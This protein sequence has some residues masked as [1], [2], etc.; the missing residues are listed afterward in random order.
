MKR[1]WNLV[2]A[3]VLA[4][5]MLLTSSAALAA[6]GADAAIVVCI[7]SQP[8]TI[9]PQMNSA[10]DGS[11][12]IKHLFEGLLKYDW[13]GKGIVLGMAESYETSEDGLTW[14]FKIR[15]DAKWSD[16]KDL[17]AEDFVYTWRRLVD[18]DNAAP[19]AGDM[20]QFLLNGMAI[21]NGEKAPEE[22]GV[23]AIDAKTLEVKLENPCAF[24][25][26]IMAFPAY[27]P[28][29]QDIVEANGTGW[30]N[31]P[32]TLI[33][34][35]AYKLE[36]WTMDE[37]IVLVPNPEYYDVDKVVAKRLVFKLLSDPIAKLAAVRNGE[38]HWTDD[39]PT[40][41]IEATKAENL[42]HVEPQL[43]TYY[44]DIN[45]SKAPF[46]NVLVRKALSLAI[47]PNYL[48]EVAIGGLYL[49]AT[50]FVGP[51]FTNADGSQFIDTQVIIDRSDYEANKKAAQE[52]L[53]EAGY[54]NGEGFPTVEYGTNQSGVHTP[55]MEAL[56]AMWKDVLG[57]NVVS[58]QVEWSVFLPMRRNG[59]HQ[60]A[61]NGWV[62]DYNDASNL[63]DLFTS[64][65]GNN[66]TQY[67]SPEFDALMAKV[68]AS[69]DAA[70]R[71]ALMHEAEK[72]AIG[73]D[74]AAVPVYYYTT[75]WLANPNIKGVTTYPTGEKFFFLAHME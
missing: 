32:A 7:G 19:Y 57:I 42:F 63:L 28:V 29:R 9:D 55:T 15:P 52:A 39:V 23:T 58:S 35:G 48:A 67:R 33:G 21:V 69:T 4:V 56:M 64:T 14:T 45:N 74:Y 53:A 59:E 24:F 75:L 16:G 50:N 60:L 66:S 73:T 17:T 30:I 41:E 40:E 5:T 18:R 11:N 3:L 22:L 47:D 70:E 51:G 36:S 62:A 37:E 65:S 26:D 34:N 27:Y 43:G 6:G 71:S 13:E 44:V 20:G 46:D 8:E 12:Y 61:R 25:T 2:V 1:T 49:P 38:I 31:T 72:L 54:P 10:S 68:K